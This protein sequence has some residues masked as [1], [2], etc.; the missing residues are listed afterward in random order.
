[1]NRNGTDNNE[2]TTSVGN[3]LRGEGEE[4]CLFLFRNWRAGWRLEA[5]WLI[6]GDQ[7]KDDL[8]FS[9]A[10]ITSHRLKGAPT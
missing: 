6:P 3:V 10:G 4:P 7:S 1:M 2:A 8:S 5:D 9:H